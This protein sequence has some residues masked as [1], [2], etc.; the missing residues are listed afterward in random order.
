M[1]IDSAV[2]KPLPEPSIYLCQACDFRF[3]SGGDSLS[4]PKCGTSEAE[5][6]VAIY[7]EDDVER[8][9]LY[10]NIDWLPGD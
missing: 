7:V 9:E 2:Q 4:C 5:H 6:L 1:N 10:S 3:A 8:Y